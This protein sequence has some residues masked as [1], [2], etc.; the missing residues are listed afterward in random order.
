VGMPLFPAPLS[1]GAI[2]MGFT[3]ELYKL[4]FEI[5]VILCNGIAQ[6][7]PGGCCLSWH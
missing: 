7:I 6:S 2:T 4:G 1:Q 3:R 5:S